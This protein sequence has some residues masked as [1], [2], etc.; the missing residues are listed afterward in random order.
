[1]SGP[2]PER[3]LTCSDEAVAATVVALAGVEAL[4]AL[5]DGAQTWVAIELV[6]G[7][8]VGDE[9]LCHAGIALERLTTPSP[10]PAA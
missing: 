7:A 9:L 5:P 6:P 3:C 2:A 8:A 4:V 1:M 10:G